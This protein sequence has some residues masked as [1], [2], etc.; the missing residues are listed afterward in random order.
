MQQVF[1]KK[2][3]YLLAN[4]HIDPIWQWTLDE[5]IA[6]TV[7]TF[8]SACNLLDRYD[9]IFCHNESMLYEWIEKND[10]VLFRRICRH[11]AAGK[12]RI[13]GG[14]FLQPDCNLSRGESYVRQIAEGRRYFR[15][16]FGV[17]PHVAVNVDSFGHS[18]GLVQIL[19]KTGF[20]GY[21]CCR[22]YESELELPG[23]AF[24]WV[25][26]DGSKVRAVRVSSYNS[27]LGK[28]DEK[29]RS[30]EARQAGEENVLVLWGVGNH[31]GG[32]SAADLEKIALLQKNGENEYVH[33]SPEDFFDA[34]PN[35]AKEYAGSL[36]PCMPGCYISESKLKSKFRELENLYY[37]TERMCAAAARFGFKAEK[38]LCSV[39]RKMLIGMFHDTLP[40]S[41]IQDA[42]TQTSQMLDG[43]ISE[44]RDIR[45][46]AILRSARGLE[47]TKA[48]EYSV[49]ACNPWPYPVE[50]TLECEF[51]LADQD[52]SE[53][54][55]DIV[56]EENGRGIPVQVI[57]E[58]SNIP[59]EWRKRVAFHAR[60]EPFSVQKF[61]CRERLSDAAPK[62]GQSAAGLC[63]NNGRL[64]VR[65]GEN[66]SPESISLYGKELLGGAITLS[67]FG[68]TE[69]PWGMRPACLHRLGSREADFA[70][71]QGEE[72]RAWSGGETEA[73]PVRI[74][75]DGEVL[76][77]IETMVS[78]SRS[79]A[80][81]TWTLYRYSDYVDLS[82][83]VYNNEKYK[84]LK[85]C[86]PVG[87]GECVRQIPF[88]C[89]AVAAGGAENAMLGYCA[90]SGENGTLL[91]CNDGSFSVSYE[92][93][94]MQ[95][96]L[97]RS[98]AYTA[99]P[100][101]DRRV[102]PED[103]FVP[104]MDQGEHCYRF[105]LIPGVDLRHA[106][107]LTQEFAE[108]PYV[109]NISVPRKEGEKPL[110]PFTL[111]EGGA[112]VSAMRAEKE[113]YL[114]R[115]ANEC[116]QEQIQSLHAGEFSAELHF[117]PF[118]VKTV[119]IGKTVSECEQMEW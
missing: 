53:T 14:W 20:D 31:G 48:G 38:E 59:I 95:I 110:P 8:E 98:A 91:V 80:V 36:N 68:D 83:R 10:P 106:S 21:L 39:Q 46:S 55:H 88:G 89:E 63:W 30:E 69:D 82:V 41:C 18:R 104:R 29:I 56:M 64:Y 35:N 90:S 71:M 92:E 43:A 96:A 58:R 2:K 22:P 62:H 9:F 54:Y 1:M 115:L 19:A 94:T 87:A 6:A 7:S 52:F 93:G 57:R 3:V 78:C 109:L 27:K 86:I 77:R 100:I 26:L 105:R 4:A 66:G 47:P 24:L 32:P 85:L 111:S 103:R 114:L 97:L 42:E 99:H 81:L 45:L 37:Q 34:F 73:L 16:K 76:T 72:L 67:I 28:V 101:G 12:W 65:F 61:D 119:R 23:N 15:E 118:E 108:Q 50:G 5:G 33:S 70:L 116:G 84:L 79:V 44:L 113:G 49:L 11:V 117:R 102:L 74:V 13:M 75:E 60:L 107:R 51:M 17:C 40:G 25:G 112:V